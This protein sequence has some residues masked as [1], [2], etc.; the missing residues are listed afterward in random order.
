MTMTLPPVDVM[1]VTRSTVRKLS[2]VELT[3]NVT[4]A[5][6][7]TRTRQ[8][9]KYPGSVG[10]ISAASQSVSEI[11]PDLV[12]P[13]RAVPRTQIAVVAGTGQSGNVTGPGPVGSSSPQPYPS[14]TVAAS[15]SALSVRVEST[16][17]PT[18][19][20]DEL[21]IRHA[22]RLVGVDSLPLAEILLVR[23]V[24]PLEPHDLRVPFEGE[25]VRRDAVEEPA[26]VGDDDRAPREID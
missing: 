26:V 18:L 19:R 14:V 5:A 23:L 17:P 2:N 22:M 4:S 15:A 25:D 3:S 21:A 9:S 7:A 24:V 12:S 1:E 16:A 8:V 20:P 10:L 11:V 6:V 13:T